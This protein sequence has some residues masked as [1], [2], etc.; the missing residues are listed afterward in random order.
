MRTMAQP[1]LWI[2]PPGFPPGA[3]I[4]YAKSQVRDILK[5]EFN[6]SVELQVCKAPRETSQSTLGCLMSASSFAPRSLFRLCLQVVNPPPRFIFRVV[7]GP[8]VYTAISV[9]G[10]LQRSRR[11]FMSVTPSWI[12]PDREYQIHTG[13][14]SSRR[15]PLLI[16]SSR[17]TESPGALHCTRFVVFFSR[18]SPV[19]CCSLFPVT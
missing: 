2:S 6:K 11:R 1:I 9:I 12:S 4:G 19:Q 8:V 17:S 15:P 7:S 10:A 3:T 16:I 13:T 5:A 14:S 18:Y